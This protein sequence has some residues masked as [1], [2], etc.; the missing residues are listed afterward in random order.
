MAWR[1]PFARRGGSVV[2]PPPARS[3]A[4]SDDPGSL[5]DWQRQAWGYYKTLG[6]IHYGAGF[7]ARMLSGVRLFVEQRDADG[8]WVEMEGESP[9]AA[10]LERLENARGGMSALQ[11]SYGTLTFVQGESMLC[12]TLEGYGEDAYGEP[13]LG[14][15]GEAYTEVWEMLSAAELTYS[16]GEKI[17]TRRR[18]GA[19]AGEK[20]QETDPEDPQPGTM[21]AYRFYHRDPEYSGLADSSMRAVLS[22]CEELLLL[23][24]SIRNTARNR[25]AGNGVLVLPSSMGGDL[26]D[27]GDGVMVPKNAKAIFDAL[28]A[29][30]ANEQAA[31]AVSP[32]ILFAPP[33]T[34]SSTA[35]HID[36]RGAALYRE[37][38]L[39]DECIRRIAIGLDM[40]PENL[41]GTAGVN[42]WTAWQIDEAAW[43][44]HGA[45]VARE[46]VEQLTSALLKPV[47]LDLG[48]DPHDIR[49]W[50]DATDVVEDPDRG[51][52][53]MDAHDRLIISDA[54]A[55]RD[56]GFD[57]DDAPGIQ[58][59]MARANIK[60]RGNV[61][62]GEVAPEQAQPPVQASVTPERVIGMAEAAVLRCRELAGSRL[63][64]R[65]Q[66]NGTA[67]NLRARIKSAPN[68]SVAWRLGADVRD[69]CDP[70]SLVAGAGMVFLTGMRKLGLDPGLA[71][72]LVRRVEEHAA[73]TLFDEDSGDLP[74]EVIGIC[75]LTSLRV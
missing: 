29:P 51:H 57:E 36:L 19:G 4:K 5:K 27:T 59:W 71:E 31:S 25:G 14:V 3:G 41:L 33:D 38:G 66:S 52:A 50:Y 75:A 54:S 46:L 16:K 18:G 20:Y 24:Q 55:R 48:I 11:G 28:T 53:A 65:M 61:N 74:D 6:E 35:F 69:E 68:E 9:L 12:C 10:Q 32:L 26:I 22:D 62:V 8:D 47:A 30:I 39:R 2:A 72:S 73:R 60:S 64:T 13:L 56:L 40:P 49:V 44:N 70:D 21:I 45:P 63:R 58:E 67:P 1:L 43:K 37:T 23:K 7:Y 34:T 15:D 17:Y 42:H